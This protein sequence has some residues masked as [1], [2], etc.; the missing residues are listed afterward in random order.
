MCE[1]RVRG[2][3][4]TLEVWKPTVIDHKHPTV[5]FSAGDNAEVQ[6]QLVDS[7]ENLEEF[8]RKLLRAVQL[9]K[10][11]DKADGASQPQEP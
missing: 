1:A 9:S 11:E 5:V 10:K 6:I 8:A 7:Y 2:Y 3:Q 4:L